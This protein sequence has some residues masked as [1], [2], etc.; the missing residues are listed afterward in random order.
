MTRRAGSRPPI[1]RL[2]EN[3]RVSWTRPG[4]ARSSAHFSYPGPINDRACFKSALS[5]YSM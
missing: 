4:V 1:P 2:L 5:L 3:S